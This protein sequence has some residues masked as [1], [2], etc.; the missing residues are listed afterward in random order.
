MHDLSVMISIKLDEIKPVYRKYF[1]DLTLSA[2]SNQFMVF[3]ANL[4]S[5]TIILSFYCIQEEILE[6]INAREM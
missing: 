6:T 4:I 3:L 5:A 2:R 1:N